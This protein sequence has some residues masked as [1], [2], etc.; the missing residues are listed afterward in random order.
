MPVSWPA[1]RGVDDMGAAWVISGNR[2]REMAWLIHYLGEVLS[3]G[4]GFIDTIN[5]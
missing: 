2:R 3:F 4:I 5:G 1:P